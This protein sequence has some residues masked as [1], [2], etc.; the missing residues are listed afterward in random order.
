MASAGAAPVGE[1]VLSSGRA[2]FAGACHDAE[3]PATVAGTTVTVGALSPS[4]PRPCS[5]EQQKA[6]ADVLRLLTGTMKAEITAANL[7]LTRP[8]GT[9]LTLVEARN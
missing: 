3:G 9:G 1:I 2:R 6:E 4:P 8:D 5:Q 7:M